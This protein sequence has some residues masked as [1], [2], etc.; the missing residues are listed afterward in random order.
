MD[1]LWN[2][3]WLCSCLVSDFASFRSLESRRLSFS[4][5]QLALHHFTQ[6]TMSTASSSREPSVD[7]TTNVPVQELDTVRS[8]LADV[9]DGVKGVREGVESWRER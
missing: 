2:A 1:K 3:L 5:L 8:L 7:L 4:F 9:R 6:H